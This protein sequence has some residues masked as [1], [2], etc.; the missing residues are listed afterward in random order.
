MAMRIF[1]EFASGL[2]VRARTWSGSVGRPL[3]I[4]LMGQ[5]LLSGGAL[6]DTNFRPTAVLI[7][8]HGAWGAV[9]IILSRPSDV[10]VCDVVPALAQLTGDEAV[11]FEGGPVEPQHAILLVDVSDPD[12]L[13]V[14]VFDTVGFLTGDVSADVQPIVRQGRV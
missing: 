3:M 6:F 8:E 9:G 4:S 14:P 1:R 2:Y 7:A 11:L 5:L 13:D 10:K 12:V